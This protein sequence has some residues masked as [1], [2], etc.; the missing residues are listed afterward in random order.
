MVLQQLKKVIFLKHQPLEEIYISSYRM[1]LQ[2]CRPKKKNVRNHVIVEI[3]NTI[4][5]KYLSIGR[6]EVA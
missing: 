2:N 6:I 4:Q 3:F 1:T 5:G